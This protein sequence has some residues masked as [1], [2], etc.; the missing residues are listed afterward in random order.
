MENGGAPRAEL[1]F[2]RIPASEMPDAIGDMRI[3]PELAAEYAGHEVLLKQRAKHPPHCYRAFDALRLCLVGRVD[4]ATCE[5][6]AAAYQPC[7]RELKKA[8]VARM[9]AQEDERRKI[10]AAKAKIL[11]EADARGVS[12]GAKA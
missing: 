12:G 6:V 2:K 5:K 9:M 3:T 7:A 8:K 1:K 4:K 10:L 11:D